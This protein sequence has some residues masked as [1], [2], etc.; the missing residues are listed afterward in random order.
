MLDVSEVGVKIEYLTDPQCGAYG[1]YNTTFLH[2]QEY[3]LSNARKATLAL[4]YLTG[5]GVSS[6]ELR[7]H[8]QPFK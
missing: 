2:P 4:L 1:H 7:K 5:A 3:L 8:Y 6:E